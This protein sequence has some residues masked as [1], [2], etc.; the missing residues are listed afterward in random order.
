MKN[1]KTGEAYQDLTKSIKA[2]ADRAGVSKTIYNHL[3]RGVHASRLH[4]A[5]VPIA[6][7]QDQLGHED[8]GTTRKYITNTLG[9]RLESIKKMDGYMT[10]EKTRLRNKETKKAKTKHENK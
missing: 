1:D 9:K 6:D 10:E 8:I 3:F 7:I 5:G 4:D 2:A